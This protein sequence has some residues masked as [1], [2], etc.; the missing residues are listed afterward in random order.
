MN[1]PDRFDMTDCLQRKPQ[2][3]IVPEGSSI[4]VVK[5]VGTGFALGL[6]SHGFAAALTL[7]AERSVGLGPGRAATAE[8]IS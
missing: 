8:E 4:T 1:K 7:L 5:L 2:L 3:L 6:I